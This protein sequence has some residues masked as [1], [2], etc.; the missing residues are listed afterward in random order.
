[1]SNGV[2]LAT[3]AGTKSTAVA[4][5]VTA[6]LAAAHKLACQVIRIS[7]QGN[8][9]FTFVDGGCAFFPQRFADISGHL[10]LTLAVGLA[11]IP[12]DDPAHTSAGRAADAAIAESWRTLSLSAARPDCSS[13]T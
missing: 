11:R 10:A 4:V 13:P 5:Y 6:F 12:G 9:V 8:D 3:A 7:P 2:G 1:M